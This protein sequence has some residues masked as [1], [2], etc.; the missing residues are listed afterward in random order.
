MRGDQNWWN[1]LIT[2]GGIVA[3]VGAAACCA[4]PLA[5]ASLGLGTAWLGSI[6]PAVAPFR[7]PLLLIAAVLLSAGTARLI[8]QFRRVQVC[9]TD[10]S[11]GKP[12]YRLLTAAGLVIGT[13]LLAGAVVYV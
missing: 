9:P 5:L 8:W 1:G 6:S 3:S 13:T 7:T 2:G 12:A 4:L 11:C 10:A